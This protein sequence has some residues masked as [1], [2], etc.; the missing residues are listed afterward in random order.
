[1]SLGGY[2]GG[3]G[4]GSFNAGTD[5]V[6]L[7]GVGTAGGSVTITP[8]AATCTVTKDGYPPKGGVTLGSSGNGAGRAGGFTW[9]YSAMDFSQFD[10]LYQGF[11]TAALPKVSI[12]TRPKS[13]AVQSHHTE[14]T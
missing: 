11:D 13:V 12:E 14:P 7:A 1:M 10:A 4:G 3:G 6:N 8:G 2:N 5:Q 9:S